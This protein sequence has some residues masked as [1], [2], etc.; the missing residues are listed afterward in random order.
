MDN[1]PAFFYDKKYAHPAHTPNL[2][3][4]TSQ[5]SLIEL[6]T[7]W[8]Y[9]DTVALD[10]QGTTLLNIRQLKT[11]SDFMLEQHPNHPTFKLLRAFCIFYLETEIEEDQLIITDEVKLKSGAADFIEGFYQF[12]T[13]YNMDAA[14]LEN[15]VSQFQEKTIRYKSELKN[16]MNPAA[17][18]LYLELRNRWL[19][20]FKEKL[21]G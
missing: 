4:D 10:K 8:K 14:T 3:E 12:K 16:I 17:K 20:Q 18:L 19:R 21:Y 5:G 7:V 15:A 2:Q 13:L 11:S 9:M 1:S 6:E